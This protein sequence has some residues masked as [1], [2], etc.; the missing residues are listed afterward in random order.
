MHLKTGGALAKQ[1]DLII[2]ADA[3][4]S[5]VEIVAA[6]PDVHLRSLREAATA[7]G[8]RRSLPQSSSQGL[9]C[10]EPGKKNGAAEMAAAAAA[11]RPTVKILRITA[12]RAAAGRP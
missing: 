4:A 6:G 11:A 3:R 10:L 9:W 2:A 12:Q 1:A 8:K 5:R 7:T